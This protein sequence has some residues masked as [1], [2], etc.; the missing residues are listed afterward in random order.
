MKPAVP[1]LGRLQTDSLHLPDQPK[2]KAAPAAT[3]QG[4]EVAERHI[5]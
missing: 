1:L 3:G 5:S 4:C 2:I